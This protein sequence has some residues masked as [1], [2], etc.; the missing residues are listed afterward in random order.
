MMASCTTAAKYSSKQFGALITTQQLKEAVPIN[1]WA[2]VVTCLNPFTVPGCKI[3]GLKSAQIHTCKQYIW[4]SYNKF[5]F[6]TV[7]FGRS[8]FTCSCEWGKSCND[9]KFGTFI[10][11]LPSDGMA[12]KAVK[13]LIK[14]I[15]AQ[16]FLC[17]LGGMWI[18][19]TAS[20]TTAA[21]Y[22]SKQLI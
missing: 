5:S 11:Q 10:G 2:A 4:W 18:V 15:Q 21:K 7:H 14:T 17:V 20:G 3:F 12:S 22:S 1:T 9:F 19:M 13:G 16:A 8:P 6:N